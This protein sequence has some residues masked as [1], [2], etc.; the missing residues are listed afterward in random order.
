MS[1]P[2]EVITIEYHPNSLE[3]FRINGNVLTK[4]GVG[5]LK[6]PGQP[7]G[8]QIYYNQVDFIRTAGKQKRFPVYHKV[9]ETVTYMGE[10]SLDC[11]YK[12]HSF[13][14]FTYFS[15]TLRRQLWP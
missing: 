9:G 3:G 10:Y 1:D 14:G 4:I 13:E 12:R 5:R 7:A 6:S 2:I 15:Y 8:N 11:I